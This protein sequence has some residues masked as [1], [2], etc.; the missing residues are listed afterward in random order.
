MSRT[1]FSASRPRRGGTFRPQLEALE[2]RFAPGSLLETPVLFTDLG[3]SLAAK[4]RDASDLALLVGAAT[5]QLAATPPLSHEAAPPSNPEAPPP[6]LSTPLS[7]AQAP[8]VTTRPVVDFATQSIV[9]GESTLTR[10]D[11][12]ITIHLTATGVPAGVYSGWIAIFNP[13]GTFPV[14]AGRVAGHVV[15]EGGNLT[16]SVHLNEGEIISGHPV[17]P[18]GSLQDALR[19]EIRMVVRY[20]GPADPGRIYEQ[21]HTFEPTRAFN[22]LI[23]IHQ[24]P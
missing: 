24:A 16:F 6:A 14:A 3:G 4:Q 11:Q 12:G 10:T 21:T 23:T 18:S 20:H 9:F 2:D 13:G 7:S 8:T 1:P 17:F 15:G 5:S 22:F 19:Q